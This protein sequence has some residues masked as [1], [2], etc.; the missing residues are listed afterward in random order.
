[1]RQPELLAP[2]GDMTSLQCAI[3]A[4][5]DAVYLGLDTLN[6]RSMATRHFTLDNLPEASRRCRQSNTK[7]YLT[8]NAIVYEEEIELCENL[9]RRAAGFID[10]VIAADWAVIG[11][12]RKLGLPFH[13]STQMSCSN[14]DA[15]RFLKQQGASRIVLARECSLGEV[16]TIIQKARIEVEA[17]VHGALCVAVS[18]RCLLSHEAYGFSANRGE[19][20]QPCRRQYHIKETQEGDQAN[21]E[22]RVQAHTV[23]S[24]RDLCSLPFVDRLM[25]AG[26]ASFKIEGRARNPEYV[27]TVVGAYRAAI[28]SVL[29]G[30]FTTAVAER[31]TQECARVYHRPFST[32]LYYGRPGDEPLCDT[33]E[34]QATEKKIYAG[35]VQNYYPQAGMAQ[36]LI[37]DRPIMIGDRIA[38]HGSTTGVLEWDVTDLRQDERLLQ[39]VERSDWATLPCPEKVRRNDKVYVIEPQP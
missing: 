11:L 16:A 13:V 14:S 33:D 20:L 6:M 22:F 1:M 26:I 10:A 19:C 15:A 2:A 17:F 25:E 9:L 29:D 38:V 32:G 3:T 4:G 24:A 30:T 31:L 35:I 5:A 12:C 23:L 34:N 39:R 21:A 36:V 18:G 28:Q 37:H 8:L 7:L 27:K